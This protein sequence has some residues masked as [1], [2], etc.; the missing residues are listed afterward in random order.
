MRGRRAKSDFTIVVSI[1]GQSFQSLLLR[2]SHQTHTHSLPTRYLITSSL[3]FSL[4]PIR[5][6][7]QFCSDVNPFPLIICCSFPARNLVMTCSVELTVQSMYVFACRSQ[8]Y[9]FFPRGTLRTLLTHSLT[10]QTTDHQVNYSILSPAAQEDPLEG[11]LV[12][13][14]GHS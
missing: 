11:T 8:I 3:S 2:I 14:I 4:Y 13:A 9:T 1:H 12:E 10:V 6:L 7:S 5:C